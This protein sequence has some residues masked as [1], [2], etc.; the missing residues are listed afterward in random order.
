MPPHVEELIR[1]MIMKKRNVSYTQEIK[2][3]AVTLYFHFPAAYK[4]V[5]SSFLKCL[6][7]ET[8]LRRWMRNF[9]NE[10][11]ICE[12]AIQEIRNQI[13]QSKK[14]NKELIFILVFD[15]MSIRKK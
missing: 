1:K 6:P 11:G 10:P 4:Y 12:Q 8:S 9:N 7:H 2:T 14:R 15:K 3:F 13:N 5:R